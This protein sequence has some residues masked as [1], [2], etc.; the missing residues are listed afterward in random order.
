MV[1]K[2]MKQQRKGNKSNETASKGNKSKET[3]TEM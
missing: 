2:V 1:I 3:V